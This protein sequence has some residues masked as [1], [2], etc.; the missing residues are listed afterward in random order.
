MT[1]DGDNTY[2]LS[3]GRTFYAHLGIIGI[4]PALDE[5]SHGYDGT[6]DT[7]QID[8]YDGTSEPAWTPA[9]RAELADEMIRRWQT[10]KEVGC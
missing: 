1:F 9:E 8:H 4:N 2:T 6:V 7:E 10:W 3:S 5:I